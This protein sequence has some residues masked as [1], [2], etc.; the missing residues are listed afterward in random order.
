MKIVGIDFSISCP[1][2]CIYDIEKNTYDLT[3]WVHDKKYRK[4]IVKDVKVDNFTFTCDKLERGDDYFFTLPETIVKHISE[5]INPTDL[6]AIEEY[7]FSGSG[8]ITKLAENVGV[9]KKGLY[10]FLG[11]HIDQISIGQGKT[12]TSI[13]MKGNASKISS[14]VNFIQVYAPEA[15]DKLG[16][17]IDNMMTP[18]SDW[19]DAFGICRFLYYKH[20]NNIGQTEKIPAKIL[21]SVRG[22]NG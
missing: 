4:M 3:A 16:Y 2:V 14:M 13:G 19:I 8:Q 12:C 22:K 11:H 9:L 6:V 15:L 7:A 18:F 20:L 21:K 5:R 17:T 10:E 1:A